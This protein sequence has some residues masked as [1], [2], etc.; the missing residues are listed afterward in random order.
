MFATCLTHFSDVYHIATRSSGLVGLVQAAIVLSLAFPIFAAPFARAAYYK[1]VTRFMSFREV[2]SPPAAWWVRRG[3]HGSRSAL[4]ANVVEAMTPDAFAAMMRDRLQRIRRA[5][6]AAYVIFVVGTGLSV[7]LHYVGDAAEFAIAAAALGIGPALIN[8]TPRTTPRWLLAIVAALLT[9]SMMFDRF[10][11][12][13]GVAFGFGLVFAY[14]VIG[15][16]RTLRA[17]YVPLYFIALGALAGVVAGLITMEGLQRCLSPS[18]SLKQITDAGL[19]AATTVGFTALGIWIANR[20]IA[21]LARLYERGWVSDISLVFLFG[22]AMTAALACF[23]PDR[24]DVTLTATA[25]A[26][27]IWVALTVGA[28]IVVLCASPWPAGA[29]SLLVL[30]V[31]SK[32]RSD[33]LLD[34]VQTAWRYAGPVLQIGGPDLARLNINPYGF[35]LFLG[36]RMRELFLPGEVTNERLLSGLDLAPDREG[37]FRIAEV[38]CFDSAW[39]STVQALIET[40]DAILLDLRGFGPKRAGTGFELAQI[41]SRGR[42]DRTVIVGDSS[43]DWSCFEALA[44]SE[45][46]SVVRLDA[47]GQNLVDSCIAALLQR[48]VRPAP[49]SAGAGMEGIAAQTSSSPQKQDIRASFQTKMFEDLLTKQG[50]KPAWFTCKSDKD[51]DLYKS[52]CGEKFSGNAQHIADIEKADCTPHGGLKGPPR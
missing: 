27:L 28:Y 16:N 46:K 51:C 42:L 17:L 49:M 31:F 26:C 29:C 37:R 33:R 35:A 48:G 10:E 50:F 2:R 3:R 45:A 8:A 44:G 5:T 1:R 41:A 11:D 21:G 30:R 43:T 24:K 6:F 20:F 39:R 15:T 40:S 47:Q 4:A 22:M 19:G 38:F 36:R 25:V 34:K 18:S 12:V 14:Y 23:W 32:S 13:R 52:V 9:I 7:P